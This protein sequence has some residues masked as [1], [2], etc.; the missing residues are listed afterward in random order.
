MANLLTL[1]MVAQNLNVPEHRIHYLFRARKIQD[2][3]KVGGR[4]MFTN[5]DVKRI[6]AALGMKLDRNQHCKRKAKSK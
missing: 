3:Q 4:R 2:V 6:A 1:G 5:K